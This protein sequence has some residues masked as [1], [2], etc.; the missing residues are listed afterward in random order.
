MQEFRRR[1]ADSQQKG[2]E[3]GTL[4]SWHRTRRRRRVTAGAGAAA[5][6]M[7]WAG[8][9]VSWHLAPSDTAM[10]WT[11]GLF[12]GSVVIAVP[13]AAALNTA[14]RGATS[15]AEATLDERQI[16]DRLRA[17]TI[18]HRLMLLLLVVLVVGVLSVQGDRSTFV[19]I[20]AVV[21][22]VVALFTTHLQLPLLVAGWRLPDPPPD[23]EDDLDGDDPEGTDR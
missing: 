20:A 5:A 8:T 1:W 17:H 9:V 4:P 14:T 3:R 6:A 7:Q 21:T 15:L 11:I 23:D 22:G 2:L 10:Y 19:P 12:L 13:V 18:A 16:A